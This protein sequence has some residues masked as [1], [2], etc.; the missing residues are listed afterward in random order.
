MK[1][2]LRIAVLLLAVSSL[3]RAD[4]LKAPSYEE[5][6]NGTHNRLQLLAGAKIG[7]PGSGVSGK[8][9]DRAYVAL[10]STTENAPGGPVAT[11]VAPIAPDALS[12]FTCTFWYYLDEQGP[13]LQVPISTASLLFLLTEKGF[14][15]RIEN[16]LEQ[17]RQ[18]VFSP[19]INGPLA[20]WRDTNKWIF[21]AFSWDQAT[22]TL[23]VHQGTP[24]AAVAY[25]RDMTRPVPAKPS[26]PRTDLT[27]YP[28]TIGNTFRAY[29]RP[30]AGRMDNVRFFERVLSRAELEAIRKADVA[31]V[32]VNLN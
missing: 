31:N 27:R 3:V 17:P 6:F 9:D 24:S 15:V 23:V 2:L 1:T 18:Y 10:P 16:S 11:A 30:L 14:E 12:A 7:V 32:P 26:L 22:N 13:V 5:S 25:M 28:E 19:G 21:A 4:V 29:D 8:T 20:G